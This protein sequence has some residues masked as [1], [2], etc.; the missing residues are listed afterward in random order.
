MARKRKTKKRG[1]SAA[2]SKVRAHKRGSK[3]IGSY[4]RKKRSR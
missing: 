1:S 3:K 2:C 4:A